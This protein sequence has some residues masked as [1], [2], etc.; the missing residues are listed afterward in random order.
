MGDDVRRIGLITGGNANLLSILGDILSSDGIQ[1]LRV[2]LGTPGD[3]LTVDLTAECGFSW[4]PGGGGGGGIS[5]VTGSD[6]VTVTTPAPGVRNATNDLVT[7]TP[8]DDIQGVSNGGIIF[9]TT[10]GGSVT[11]DRI[12]ILAAENINLESANLISL[13]GV[14]ASG[15]V[16]G[17]GQ[18]ITLIAADEITATAENDFDINSNEGNVVVSAGILTQIQLNGAT[19]NINITTNAAAGPTGGNI[20]LNADS[21][22]NG[23]IVIETTNSGVPASAGEID[24]FASIFLNLTTE[25]GQIAL[26]AGTDSGSGGIVLSAGTTGGSILL[27]V[28]GNASSIVLTSTKFDVSLV[29]GSVDGSGTVNIQAG[30]VVADTGRQFAIFDG[31]GFG[32]WP[33]VPDASGGVVIDAE[34]RAAINAVL[35]ALETWGWIEAAG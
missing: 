18:D 32:Q 5:N 22:D 26:S 11:P 14:T 33:N 7:G 4:Q 20:R 28:S 1:S 21:A 2:P 9:D 27:G 12:D 16:L 3:V 34:A 10:G 17:S 24:I 31:V 23:G 19:G 6:G 15:I 25:D 8:V 30:A 35:N 29:A 13:G